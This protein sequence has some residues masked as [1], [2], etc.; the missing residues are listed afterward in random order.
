MPTWK[1]R[2]QEQDLIEASQV[3]SVSPTVGAQPPVIVADVHHRAV[4]LP[5]SLAYG[6][7]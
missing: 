5:A 7:R 4:T 3:L 2:L 1:P 6:G